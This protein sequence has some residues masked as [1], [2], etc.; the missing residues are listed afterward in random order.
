M[1]AVLVVLM[2]VPPVR[3]LTLT[4]LYPLCLLSLLLIVP[5]YA[6][7]ELWDEKVLKYKC[8]RKDKK[9]KALYNSKHYKNRVAKPTGRGERERDGVV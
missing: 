9:N 7:E 3:P 1:L 4:N 8:E 2:L 6:S 5:L